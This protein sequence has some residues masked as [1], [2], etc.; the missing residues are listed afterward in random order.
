[1]SSQGPRRVPLKMQGFVPFP[2]VTELGLACQGA[3]AQIAPPSDREYNFNLTRLITPKG[4]QRKLWII[5]FRTTHALPR[6]SQGWVSR[7]YN[8]LMPPGSCPSIGMPM[9]E[10]R[11]TKVGVQGFGY[12]NAQLDEARLLG[13]L[14]GAAK[15]EK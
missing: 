13:R 6:S 10:T 8:F 12:R 4:G 5:K 3:S 1:M 9:A 14:P 7:Q 11:A 15:A 2:L